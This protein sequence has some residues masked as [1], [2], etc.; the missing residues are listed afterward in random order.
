MNL[1]IKNVMM[2]TSD[3]GHKT[4]Q[5]I[6]IKGE[7]F[8]QYEP[9]MDANADHII[10]GQ[11]YNA[12]PGLIDF[13][14]H[15]FTHGSGFGVNPDLLYSTGVTTAVDMGTA[16]RANFDAFYMTDI[17][18]RQMRVK[19]FLNISPIGQPGK[20]IYEPLCKSCFAE[21]EMEQIL[22]RYRENI[23][24]LKVRLSKEIVGELDLEPLKD[25]IAMGDRWN[26]PVAVHTTNPPASPETFVQYLRPGDIYLHTFQGKGYTILDNHGHVLPEVRKAQEEGVLFEVGQGR[27]NLDDEIVQKAIEDNFFPDI[28]STDATARTLFVFEPMKSLPNLASKFLGWGMKRRSV[29]DAV[30]TT[31]AKVLK[32]NNELGLIQP[33]YEADVCLYEIKENTIVPRLTISRGQVVFCSPTTRVD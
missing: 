25:A 17:L 29:Y 15:L 5:T 26:L 11:K 1:V 20:G 27:F 23:V 24:G 16:G 28:I 8:V 2:L 10:D 3:C 21:T 31:P 12:I 13:H 18:P 4:R 19:S 33:G 22:D 9:G 14:T 32:V 30:I 7:K 6:A